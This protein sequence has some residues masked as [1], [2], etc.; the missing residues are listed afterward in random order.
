MNIVEWCIAIYLIIINVISVVITVY[1][2]RSA[3]KHKRRV[4]EKELMLAA[5]LSGCLSMYVTMIIIHHKTRHPK[6]MI[7]I[8]VIFVLEVVAFLLL[9]YFAV[10]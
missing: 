7:G 6:F 10:N 3:I 2:K 8:P 4:P 1:D 9:R 5:A